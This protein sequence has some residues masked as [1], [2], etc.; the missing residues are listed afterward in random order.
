[1][2]RNEWNEMMMIDLKINGD[3]NKFQF[4]FN[5]IAFMRSPVW[6][7]FI[8]NLFIFSPKTQT[9]IWSGAVECVKYLIFNGL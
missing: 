6:F 7:Y 8:L 2:K 1:M 3:D 9:V 4:D 5:A